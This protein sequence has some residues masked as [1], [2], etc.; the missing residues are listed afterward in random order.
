MRFLRSVAGLTR[1]DRR[2]NDDVQQEKGLQSVN[3]LV[4]DYRLNW[5]KRKGRMEDGVQNIT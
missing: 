3:E 2:R 5:M 1:W 4:H